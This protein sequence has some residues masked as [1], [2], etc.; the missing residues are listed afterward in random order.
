ML[1]RYLLAA[2]VLLAACEPR[3][4]ARHDMPPGFGLRIVF[5]GHSEY[6]ILDDSARRTT[7]YSSGYGLSCLRR[8]S[9]T[10]LSALGVKEDR[11]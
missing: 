6:R 9:S 7:C 3:A 1:R 8:P 11:P 10:T 4:Q 2:L 5:D